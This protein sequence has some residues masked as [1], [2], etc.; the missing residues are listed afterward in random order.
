MED[1]RERGKTRKS[2]KKPGFR[3][4][5]TTPD[6]TENVFQAK[7]NNEVSLQPEAKKTNSVLL[8]VK[9]TLFPMVPLI[10]FFV[11]Y[12]RFSYFTD[13]AYPWKFQKLCP[14]Q[15]SVK[16]QSWDLRRRG[17]QT[18]RGGVGNEGR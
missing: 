15:L 11:S 8:E 5:P 4:A 18:L 2:A 12:D 7:T 1:R 10:G 9:K 17:L 13:V 3:R 16:W 6:Q 14:R